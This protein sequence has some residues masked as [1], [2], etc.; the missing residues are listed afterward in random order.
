MSPTNQKSSFA[1][2]F[3][4]AVTAKPKTVI[5]I[6]LFFIV[7]FASFIPTLQK[8]IRLDAFI[9]PDHP[10]LMYRYKT[11][12]TF[13]LED[14]MVIAI[15][16]E[17]AQGVFNPHTLF[18]VDWLTEQLADMDKV[19]PDRIT[20]LA[21]E[22]NITGTEEGMEIEAFWDMPPKTQLEAEQVRDAIMDFPLYVGSLVAKNGNGTLIVAELN[23][24]TQAQALYLELLELVKIAPTLPGEKIYV[25]GEGAASGYLGAYI[26]ADAIRLDPIAGIIITIICLIAFRTLRGTLLPNL[27]V[28]A[29]ATASI[30][31]MAAFKVPFFVITNALPVVLIGISVADS[32]HILS[33]YYEDQNKYPE[34]NAKEIVLRT[35]SA[36]WRP[37]SLTSLTT[38]AGFVGLS[39]ASVMPPMQYFGL[40]ALIGVAVAWIYSLTVLPA[41]LTL[42]KLKPSLAFKFDQSNS[43]FEV[44]RFGRALSFMGKGVSYSP[45]TVL[46]VALI[47]VGLSSIAATK[48]KIDNSAIQV[49]S[50]SSPL[51]IA[52]TEINRLFDGTHYLDIMIETPQD[53]GLFK[54]ENLKKIEALQSYLE[55]LPHVSGTS[56]IVDYLKQM[57]R[58]LNEG[59]PNSYKLP[60]S[61]ELAAQY[62]L[63]YTSSGD[64]DDFE[65]E[66]DYDYRLANVRTVLNDGRYSIEKPVVESA[67]AYIDKHFSSSDITAT[68]SGRVNVDYHWIE[69]L[70]DSHFGSV[71]IALMLVFA[72]ASLSFGS[73]IAGLVA[74]IPV[75]LTIL[76]IYATMGITG[77]W[78]NVGTSMFAA[79]SIGLGV[80]FSIHTLERLQTL[81]R[82]HGKT[83]QE[84]LK[85]FYT[86]TGR[87]LFFN[88]LAL[89]LG[90][91]VLSISQV[92]TLKEFGLLVAVAITTAFITSLTVLPA[93]TLLFKPKFMGF[94]TQNLAPQE[95]NPST[96]QIVQ[97]GE[98]K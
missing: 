90:F 44:D 61:A 54:P 47:I 38:I 57:N 43:E 12:D 53:E 65:E 77:V 92:V 71:F 18:L 8:D 42:L 24:Q 20:S 13:G 70:A 82:D 39:L 74:L 21:T 97:T 91:G 22:N 79:I 94:K 26:D 40:F 67:Q 89:S 58:S 27:I 6:G 68:L 51:H 1:Q 84:A 87:A 50:T 45:K 15:T 28:V 59:N 83:A 29:T 66:V 16:N 96:I 7:L 14:P 81:I 78:L 75:A 25:A 98:S 60:E 56:S 31:L 35:M 80:D 10:S 88:F 93:I 4:R 9:P 3:F 69:R 49:F 23:D 34:E 37:I 64:P 63:L 11:R 76:M 95:T 30:G 17:G 19:N 85:L 5:L 72:M 55:T 73:V 48:M 2:S 46:L 33:Q 62:F 36:M 32:I 86:S 52:D 41:F